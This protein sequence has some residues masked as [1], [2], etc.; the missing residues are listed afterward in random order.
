MRPEP[1]LKRWSD[2]SQVPLNVPDDVAVLYAVRGRQPHAFTIK[3]HLDVNPN[4]PLDSQV[5]DVDIP[6]VG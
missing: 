2:I 1:V 6:G 5:R 4:A 3:V